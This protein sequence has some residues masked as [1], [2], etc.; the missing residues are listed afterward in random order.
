MKVR[1]I[2]F[3]VGGLTHSEIRTAYEVAQNYPSHDIIVG[4]RMM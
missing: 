1:V 3:V 2:V 4:K